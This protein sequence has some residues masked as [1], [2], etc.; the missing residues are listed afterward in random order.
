M[1]TALFFHKT[2][3]WALTVGN[4]RE[5]PKVTPCWNCF[6]DLLFVAIVIIIIHYGL[7]QK[8]LAFSLPVKEL[9]LSSQGDK[10]TLPSYEKKNLTRTFQRLA[11]PEMF[12]K[13]EDPLCSSSSLSLALCSAFCL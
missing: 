2:V 11:N 6:F 3:E 12:C 5:E 13:T 4:C 1:F 8:T 7:T 10:L 9:F